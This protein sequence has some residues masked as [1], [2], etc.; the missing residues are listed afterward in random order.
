MFG[1][2]LNCSDIFNCEPIPL[3]N[4]AAHLAVELGED[5][6]FSAHDYL[7]NSSLQSPPLELAGHQLVGTHDGLSSL[8]PRRDM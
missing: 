5:P 3:V 8:L 2:F 1:P 4:P 6:L 7:L